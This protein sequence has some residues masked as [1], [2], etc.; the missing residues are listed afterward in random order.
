MSCLE[1]LDTVG[2]RWL[3]VRLRGRER[4]RATARETVRDRGSYAY[5][6]PALVG[7]AGKSSTVSPISQ[8]LTLV[9]DWSATLHQRLSDQSCLRHPCPDPLAS[10]NVQVTPLCPYISRRTFLLYLSLSFFLRSYDSSVL[11]QLSDKITT[12]YQFND[13]FCRFHNA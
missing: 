6:Y 3:D 10:T 5:R 7:P 1:V 4:K 12:Y 13:F 11:Y 8:E 2:A 9:S